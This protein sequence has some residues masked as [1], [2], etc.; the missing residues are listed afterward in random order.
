MLVNPIPAYTVSGSAS[1]SSKSVTAPQ[2]SS[3]N[4]GSDS[5]TPKVHAPKGGSLRNLLKA[6]GLVAATTVGAGCPPFDDG[7]NPN[8]VTPNPPPTITETSSATATATSTLTDPVVND[9]S[10]KNIYIGK[11]QAAGILPPDAV[12]YQGS[13]WYDDGHVINVDETVNASK[14]TDNV[15]F[16]DGQTTHQGGKI[17]KFERTFTVNPDGSGT[18]AKT[19]NG[20]ETERY[21]VTAQTRTIGGQPK[22][23][24]DFTCVQG[25][26]FN[27]SLWAD[28]GTGIVYQYTNG[29]FI[30]PFN[31]LTGFRVKVDGKEPTL[32]QRTI[33]S[34]RFWTKSGGQII[35][36]VA[37]NAPA[38]LREN[39]VKFHK[40]V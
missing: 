38:V 4:F 16:L 21:K 13:S 11:L 1:S 2:Y 27:H 32:V 24:A 23:F 8:K 35:E 3:V 7:G 25:D 29:D 17:T 34:I 28:K 19:V 26:C 14:S 9:K 22:T 12:D 31:K 33:D 40:V 5:T 18:L 30:T 6:L 39:A 20:S 15:M 10:A 36:G 37:N